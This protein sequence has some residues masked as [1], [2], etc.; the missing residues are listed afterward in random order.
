MAR[1]LS[2]GDVL[3]PRADPVTMLRRGLSK[4]C[5]RCG[6]GKLYRGW[7]RMLDRCPSCGYKFAREEGFFFGAYIVNLVI[8]EAVLFGICLGYI[9]V[10]GA[11]GNDLRI[12]LIAACAAALVVP[13]VF[14]PFSRTLWSAIDLIFTPLELDEIVEAADAVGE[15]TEDEDT[16]GGDA[17]APPSS[18][19]PAPTEGPAP[20]MS[21]PS[22]RHRGRH[23]AHPRR[24]RSH[25]RP[26]GDGP[27]SG[28]V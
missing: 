15:D 5:P 16:E 28:R 13:V 7:F 2:I 25:P 9:G 20:G 19:G 14:Y 24:G 8:T 22:W 18:S 11:Q 1:D 6:G 12:S 23:R 26:G 27:G 10:H 3:H 4:H 21:D 17:D